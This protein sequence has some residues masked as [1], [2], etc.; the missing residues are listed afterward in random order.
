MLRRGKHHADTPVGPPRVMV[1]ND[2]DDACELL[3]RVL[4]RAGYS[5]SR[6][7]SHQEAL[8]ML[9]GQAAHCIVLDL[10][11]GGVGTNLKL[12]DAIRS[13]PD[14][15]VSQAR[16]VLVAKQTNNRMFSWQA[17]VDAFLVRPFH[18]DDLLREVAD[19]LSRSEEER[20]KHRRRQLSEAQG[21]GRA[22]EARPWDSQRF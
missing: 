4:D 7:A 18:A 10:A 12:L 5:V 21:E 22:V 14:A 16:V 1:V 3:S 6:A 19:S 8:S 20:A 11:T 17:G 9:S 15:A 13:Y 2:D